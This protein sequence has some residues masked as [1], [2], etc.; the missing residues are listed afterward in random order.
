MNKEWFDNELLEIEVPQVEVMT[1]I[2]KGIAEGRNEKVRIARK[3]KVKKAGII[4]ATAASL[5]LA[6]GFI[7]T[8]MTKVLASVPLIGAI[9]DD[10]HSQEGKQLAASNLVTEL[11]EKAISNGVAVTITS[12]YYDG[13]IIGVTFRAE[14]DI[15]KNHAPDNSPESGYSFHIFDGN[16]Q[17]QWAGTRESLQKKDGNYIGAFTLEYSEKEWPTAF[18]LPV[19]FTNMG[20]VQGEWTF[21]IPIKQLPVKKILTNTESVSSD[22]VY[23]LKMSS[24]LIGKTNTSFHY[25]ATMPEYDSVSLRIFDDQGNQIDENF[26]SSKKANFSSKM[27]NDA[28]YLMIY[29]EFDRDEFPTIQKLNRNTFKVE[30]ARFGYNIN[31]NNVRQSGSTVSLDLEIGNVNHEHFRKDIVRNFAENF[32]LVNSDAEAVRKGLKGQEFYTQLKSES[33]LSAHSV[34]KVGESVFNLTFKIENNAVFEDYSIMV[35]FGVFSMNEESIKL[36][37]IKIELK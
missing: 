33:L 23:G 24:I 17:K 26:A 18:T 27:I 21:D 7:F 6:S 37:P 10:F 11:N 3:T 9:Y 32:Q 28:K 1:A 29:P 12:A 35:P 25:E 14:G 4:T 13:N 34:K 2:K 19:T 30:S 15:T 20:G 36:E 16:E 22:G 31:V 5:L 8:P